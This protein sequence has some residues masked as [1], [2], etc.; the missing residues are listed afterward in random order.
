M[1]T[2][3]KILLVVPTIFASH[4]LATL[5]PR[6]DGPTAPPCRPRRLT[7]LAT[8]VD[9]H[10]ETTFD[11]LAWNIMVNAIVVTQF[12]ALRQRITHAPFNAPETKPKP[13][14]GTT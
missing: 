13:V 11:T 3:I 1:K 2:I 7:H 12:K 9:H 8:F 6:T 10:Q 4:S 14:A 5:I